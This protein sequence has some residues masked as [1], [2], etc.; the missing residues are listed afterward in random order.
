MQLALSLKTLLCKIN[1]H[2]LYSIKDIQA[3][4]IKATSPHKAPP[5]RNQLVLVIA[6]VK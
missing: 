5:P 3:I 6:L 1:S 4:F 2:S